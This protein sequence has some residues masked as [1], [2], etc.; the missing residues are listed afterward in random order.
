MKD[1]LK[2]QYGL[3]AFKVLSS[4]NFTRKIEWPIVLNWLDA[5]QDERILD[6]A[7][8]R[9]GLTLKISKKSRASVGVDLFAQNMS[10][11][12]LYAKRKRYS[13]AFIA[14][15]AQQLPFHD[16]CFDKVVCSSAVEHFHKPIDAFKEM[17][18]VLKPDG[19]LVLTVD[20]LTYPIDNEWKARHQ[21]TFYVENYYDKQRLN[22]R[23]AE[24]GFRLIESEYLLHSKVARHFL[25]RAIAY[26]HSLFLSSIN[27]L[28]AYPLV[29]AAERLSR[30]SDV[31]FT[32]IAKAKKQQSLLV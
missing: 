26:N 3:L 27:V 21:K 25:K 6:V 1:W 5:Q 28:I 31:G 20:S 22:V 12:K 30:S 16:T 15:D 4:G 18:R 23:L 17:N 2:E 24:A 29:A 14:G 19:T 13:C 32:L 9:G 11:A 8:G 10:W 7:C